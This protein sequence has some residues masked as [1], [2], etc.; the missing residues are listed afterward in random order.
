MTD[1]PAPPIFWH[2]EGSLVGGS[3]MR[4]LAFFTWNAQS[5]SGRWVRRGAMALLSFCLPVLYAFSRVF[6]TRVVH[7]LL[8]GLSQDRMDLLG[9]EYFN[10]VLK[11]R[12]NQRAEQKIRELLATKG[13]VVLVSHGLD[14]VV[15][16]LAEYLGVE[17]VL[18]NRLEFRDGLATGRLLD[19]VIPPWGGLRRLLR[20]GGDDQLPAAQLLSKLSLSL[21]AASWEGVVVPARRRVTPNLHPLVRFKTA[22][23]DDPLSVRKSLAG[24]HILLAGATGFIGKVWLANLLSDL[25]EI[26]KVYLLI[27]PQRATSALRRFEKA[28]QTSP[29]FEVLYQ[30]QGGN[31]ARFLRERVEVVEGD[32]SKPA[33]GL[34]AATRAR[35]AHRLDLVINSAGLTEFNPDLRSALGVNVDGVIHLVDFLH[36]C[37]HA[38]LL[39]VSTCYVVGMRDGRVREEL[40]PNYTPNNLADFDAERERE[41]LHALVREIERL[42][43]TP[44]VTEELKRQAFQKGAAG[45]LAETLLEHQVRKNRLRWIRAQLVEAGMRRARELGW[46]NTY[47]FT[48]SLGES[49]LAKRAADLPVAVVRPSITETS[50][51]QPFRGWNEGVTTSAPLSYLLGTYFR[52]LPSNERKCLDLIPVDLVCRGM[53]LIAAALVERRHERL[54]QL[55]TSACNPCDMRRSIELTCLAHRKHYRAQGGLELRL[56]AKFDTIPVS[57]KRYQTLSAPGQRAMVRALRRLSSPIPFAYSSLVRKERDLERVEKLIE[58]YEPFIL[59]NEHVFEA[60]NIEMLSAALPPEEQETFRYD[61]HAIDWWEYWINIHVP[62]L[63]KWTYP[64]IEGRPVEAQPRRSFRLYAP[65]ETDAGN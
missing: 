29:V 52:Q 51:H 36:E 53:T 54:Y 35:L 30:S 61:P 16:P 25:P 64:L 18:A 38:A 39:H 19:P 21:D 62:A 58:L 28:V 2:A 20:M 37:E 56:R 55:A 23:R 1:P 32:I 63:R 47:C 10:Y 24:K 9:E 45:D 40:C 22:K 42:A 17:H 48:K 44:E 60:Q 3:P 12:L 43:A 33:L 15:R 27:R 14:H 8:R 6:A 4:A 31:L 34:D 59:H 49:L 57:K 5:F 41:S 50:T 26:G 7:L 13:R 46:P 11:P 65:S